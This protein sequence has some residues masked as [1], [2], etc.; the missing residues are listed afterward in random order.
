MPD[1]VGENAAVAADK[2]R[3]LGFTRIEF[4]SQDEQDTWVLLPA[5][6]TVAKQ[7]AK[8]GTMV[9]TDTL[10]VLTCTKKR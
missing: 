7:S 3:Q 4:G 5:N 2:L 1:L 6:W 8:A 10:I 9:S